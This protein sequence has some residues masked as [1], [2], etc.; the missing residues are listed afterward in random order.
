VVENKWEFDG[1][2]DPVITAPHGIA[3]SHAPAGV[4]ICRFDRPGVKNAL[5]RSDLNA[6]ADVWRAVQDDPD[7]RVV[8][9][10]G[11]D[12]SAFC[13]GGDISD[14]SADMKVSDF[15]ITPSATRVWREMAAVPQPI[16]AAVNGDAVGVGLMLLTLCDIVVAADTARFGDPH[17]KIGLSAPGTGLFAASLGVHRTKQLLMTGRLATAAQAASM[18]LVAEVCPAAEVLPR[19]TEIATELSELPRD[20]LG[21]TKRCINQLLL[22]SWMR[23]WD[24]DC[25]FEA[26]AGSTQSHLDAVQSKLGV[27]AKAAK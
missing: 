27:T 8:V 23:T 21:W 14:M 5:R 24:A 18:G 15:A 19:A 1:K 12:G 6:W 9:L 4:L 22:E 26:L 7:V 11:S 10:T 16:V 13:S 17:V 25:A 3:L 20:A 2:G